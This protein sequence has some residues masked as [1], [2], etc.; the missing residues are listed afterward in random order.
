MTEHPGT[1]GLVFNEPLIFD[2]GKPGRK[3]CDLPEPQFPEKDP[4]EFFI[5]I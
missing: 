1:G 4:E 3:G 5:M 2:K